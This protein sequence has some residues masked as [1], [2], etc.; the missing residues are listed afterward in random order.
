MLAIA[1]KKRLIMI[2][3]QRIGDG[4][5][6]AGTLHQQHIL[7]RHKILKQTQC[8]FGIQRIDGA[9]LTPLTYRLGQSLAISAVNSRLTRRLYIQQHQC[10]DAGQHAHKIIE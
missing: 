2:S 8:F 1:A 3:R 10:V 4:V 6:V 9:Q 7:S 5:D